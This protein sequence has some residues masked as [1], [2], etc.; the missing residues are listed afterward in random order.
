MLIVSNWKAYVESKE[1]AKLLAATTAKLAKNKAHELVLCVPAPY[2]G[3]LSGTT[4]AALGAQDVSVSLGGAV[5]GEVT[6]GAVASL[7][8]TYTIVGHSERR[9]M[10]ETNV[11]IL[12]KVRHALAH[13]LTPILC[14][15]ERERD[16]DAQYLKIIRAEL[17]A[18]FDAL[19]QKERMEMVVAY[20]PLWAIG[21]TAD[22]AITVDDLREMVSY[23]RKVLGDFVPGKAASKIRVLYG[24]SAEATNAPLLAQDTGIDGFLVGHASVDPVSYAALIKSLG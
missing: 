8:A 21:K 6:A 3:L 19:T 15:G 11:T 22:E 7:G 2:V 1:K 10:G 16:E 9:A 5:T 12:E 23:I 20:E 18:V 17:S 24:G 14:V 4:G 13:G